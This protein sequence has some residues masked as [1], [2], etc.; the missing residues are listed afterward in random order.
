VIHFIAG[1]PRSGSTLLR[2]ILHQNPRVKVGVSSRLFFL[3]SNLVALMSADN[4]LTR[5]TDLQRRNILCSLFT[6]F[7]PNSQQLVFDTNRLWPA[8]IPLLKE[9]LLDFK[10]I[11]CVRNPAWILDSYERIYRRNALRQPCMFSPADSLSV[12]ARAEALMD[13]KAGNVGI[14]WQALREAWHME[15]DRLIMLPYERLLEGAETIRWIYRQLGLDADE[16]A[17]H[18][19][20]DVN[21]DP[22]LYAEYDDRVGLPGLHKISGPVKATQR[23]T[24]LP[25]DLFKKYSQLAF[26]DEWES[27]IKPQPA[28]AV[29]V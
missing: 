19:F 23:E 11:C 17:G 1:L 18:Q 16:T 21:F 4:T 15:R 2:A 28:A 29:C 9:V 12:Y 7:Y 26:W 6:S 13:P 10:I 5:V 20:Y 14:A 8:R 25:P 22:Q 24:I 27:K 3:T